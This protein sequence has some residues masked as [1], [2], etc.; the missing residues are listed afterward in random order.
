MSLTRE[1]RSVMVGGR[2]ALITG[3]REP[4]TENV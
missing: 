1:V 3:E 2:P 4:G